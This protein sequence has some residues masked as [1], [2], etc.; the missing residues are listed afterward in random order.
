MRNPWLRSAPGCYP[1]NR[2][3]AT[4]VEDRISEL[5]G[6]DSS[7]LIAV[8]KWRGTQKTV[9]LRAEALLRKRGIKQ[10]DPYY[11][12]KRVVR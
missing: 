9:R 10:N 3:G 4:T 12:L 7:K 6:F 2:I 8:I 5:K 1:V 11:F